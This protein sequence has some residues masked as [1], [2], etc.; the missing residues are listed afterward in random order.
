MLEVFPTRKS[1]GARDWGTRRT[2]T[3][4]SCFIPRPTPVLSASC[5]LHGCN[6]SPSPSCWQRGTGTN[7]TIFWHKNQPRV[8]PILSQWRIPPYPSGR[9]SFSP[10]MSIGV[11]PLPSLLGGIRI[12]P[13]LVPHSPITH[14]VPP[15]SAFNVLCFVPRLCFPL[16]SA[17]AVL[18][19]GS[20][21][22]RAPHGR[23]LPQ[24]PAA[25]PPPSA[26]YGGGTEPWGGG[27][28]GAW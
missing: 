19:E 14:P 18:M 22:F 9:V 21:S 5:P 2:D 26:S 8:P 17:S 27:C 28:G 4:S 23:L 13:S 24:H 1:D 10:E 16:G 20:V 25:S 11:Q 3:G 15:S 12:N 7:T 6:A